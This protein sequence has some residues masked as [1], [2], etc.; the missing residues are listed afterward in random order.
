MSTTREIYDQLA[1]GWYN[2]RHRTRFRTELESLAGR[3]QRGKLLN[4][5]CAHGPDF[6]P[7]KD[8]FELHGI[9]FSPRML[10]MAEKFAAKHEFRAS[11]V[12]TDARHLPYP[13]ATFDWAIA[14]ATYHHI[15]DSEER[16]RAL[17]ELY[18]VLQP[19]GEAFITVWNRWQPQFWFRSRDTLVP[20]HGRDRT[21][22]RY[23]HL[24]S[25]REME[26]VARQAGFE[27]LESSPENSYRFP[28][29]AFSRNVCVLVKEGGGP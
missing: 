14:V 23:Y 27:L 20:W 24:F 10:E 25:Y 7:F 28:I 11:L 18:R 26:K 12:E 5:G 9:D 3:W 21:L 16:L 4:V 13:D 17:I 15:E 8:S 6:L 29:K 22:Y 2:Y 19:G 1:P